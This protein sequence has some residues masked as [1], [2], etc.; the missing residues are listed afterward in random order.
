MQITYNVNEIKTCEIGEQINFGSESFKVTNII[1]AG[2][3][4]TVEAEKDEYD[5]SLDLIFGSRR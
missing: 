2:E 1:K 3:I 4:I 5:S